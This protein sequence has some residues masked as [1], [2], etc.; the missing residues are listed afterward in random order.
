MKTKTDRQLQEDVTAEL[1]WDPA[2][3]SSRV[4]VESESGI[5]TL[6]GHV[7]SY[8]EKCAAEHAAQRVSGG[9]DVVMDLTVV[10][11]GSTQRTD[12]DIARSASAALE[13]SVS[14]PRERIKVRVEDG[15][16]TL[17]GDVDWACARD[18][19]DSCVRSLIGIK[20]LINALE[21]RPQATP[22][23]VK[24][25]IEAALQRRAHSDTT[26]I[27]V[28]IKDGTVT[29]CGFVD[30]LTERSTMEHAA[31]NAPGVRNVIDH[32]VVG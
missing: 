20:G 11:P 9:K 7:G 28:S 18:A 13:W 3:E 23:D 8:A 5:I 24:V 32:F 19:A 12:E 30:S 31:W 6:S 26:S 2:V 16:V 15:W 10:L 25:R 21:I 4:G 22:K 14:V 27:D 1:A 17:S 29:L